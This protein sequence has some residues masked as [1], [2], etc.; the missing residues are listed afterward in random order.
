MVV[1]VEYLTNVKAITKKLTED[2]ELAENATVRD[3]IQK[4]TARYG[5]KMKETV[6]PDGDRIGTYVG[7][8]TKGQSFIAVDKLDA[9]LNDG[10]VV[11]IGDMMMG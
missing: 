9:K 1:N 6:L 2:I 4:L 11:L 5:M 3:L 7:V 10:D 8:A